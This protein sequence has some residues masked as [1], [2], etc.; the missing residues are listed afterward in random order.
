MDNEARNAQ[1]FR[2]DAATT[3][4]S[5]QRCNATVVPPLSKRLAYWDNIKGFLIIL[6]VFAHCLFALQNRPLNNFIVDAI[7]MFHMPAFVFV[8]GFFS[9]SDHSRSFFPMMN[10]V[11]AF[12]LLNGFFLTREIFMGGGNLSLVNP[13]FSAW[14]LLALIVWRLTIPLIERLRNI[15]P[16]LIL[17]SL[18]AGFWTDINMT[19]AAVK[20][21]VFFP[22]FMAGYLFSKESVTELQQK[23]FFPLG[24]L[25]LLVTICAGFLAHET[26]NLTDRDLLPNTYATF[27]GLFGRIAL[28]IISALSIVILLL[29]SEE[30]NI[31][32]LTK[33][34]KNSLAIYLLHRPFTLW[35]SDNFSASST[36]FQICAAI[37][38]T[39]LMTLIFG[40]DK[41]SDLLK[42]FLNGIVESLTTV[43]GA[44]FRII[45]LSF[46]ITIFCLPIFVR[47]SAPSTP[48]KI[49]RV[50]NSETATQ[51]DNSFKILFCGDLILL[52]DQVKRG[53]N[54]NGYDFAEIFEYAT[55]YISRADFAI[56]VF[57]GP[58][59]GTSKNFS[60][61]NFDD[62]KKLYLNFPDEFADAVKN[63]GFDLVT[64]A[65]NHLLDMDISGALRTIKILND[66]QIDF[67]GSYSSLD[68]KKNHR[69]KILERDGIKLAILAYTYGTNYHDTDELIGGENSFV[70]SFIVGEDSPNFKKVVK[71]VKEDFTL[72]KS[73]SPDLIIVL[74]HW[75]TQFV[76]APDKFQRTWQK[77]FIDCGADIIFGDHTH[78][79]QPIE[80]DGKNF[81]LFC[82]GN[83]ANIYREHNG[84]ASALVE[85]YIDRTTKKIIGGSIIPLWTESK[86]DGNYRALPTNEIF[87][88]KKLRGEIST[89]DFERVDEVLKHI[90][91]IMLGEEINFTQQKYF[92]DKDGF[93]RNKV[94]PLEISDDLRGDFYKALT[95]AENV[96]FVG[97]SLTEG[98]RNGGVPYFEPIEHLI[99]G[100]IFNVSQG[101]A[102]T[103]ILLDRLEEMIQSNA[104]LFVVAVGTNDVRYRDEEICSMTPEEY[105]ADLQKLRDAVKEKIST[106]KFI[107]IAPW[108]ST[109]GDFISRLSFDE[110]IKLND[111]YSAALE[112]WCAAQNEIFI[113]TNPY[114]EARLK[115][116]PNKNYLVDFIHPNADKGVELYA[117]AVLAYKQRP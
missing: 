11:I 94:K 65:N 112:N 89:R 18:A 45:F 61:S 4:K 40:S 19:F 16:L 25:L 57:E 1:A 100:K 110:K 87:T 26:F 52:E 44:A 20:I 17:F 33:A 78:S 35:F 53:F 109:D 15:L 21:V 10:L 90:T 29:A 47:I 14:Y 60:Q 105:V 116:F 101:G 46:V 50:M 93:M 43:K 64:T 41:F 107:F 6:V 8:S 92:F 88:N 117:E 54:G 62:G 114:I 91:K 99:R 70:T 39:F 75:G 48:D 22:Y 73:F 27:N 51:F 106:A 69:V 28:I 56:G 31:P 76:Y 103:K 115:I 102:T 13:Y 85:V 34:G 84:D 37:V 58:L 81:T 7:Y 63:A 96:C 38:A 67:I 74:P 108:T 55:P 104:D 36:E 82:P 113:N 66:K 95:A 32:L 111:E 83:F 98:T 23:K 79:V 77:I 9:K 5:S 80:F 30:K 68:D 3:S 2:T 72:A 71:S 59:G 86:L 97:D 42:K 12:I 49:Y 24:L